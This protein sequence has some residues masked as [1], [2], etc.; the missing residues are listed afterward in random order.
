MRNRL[1]A[2]LS[3]GRGLLVPMCVTLIPVRHERIHHGSRIRVFDFEILRTQSHLVRRGKATAPDNMI[4]RLLSCIGFE[5]GIAKPE[6]VFLVHRDP[7]HSKLC[8]TFRNSDR[9]VSCSC[10]SRENRWAVALTTKDRGQA[11]RVHPHVGRKVKGQGGGSN[12]PCYELVAW[13]TW[14]AWG[15][16]EAFRPRARLA[17]CRDH[18]VLDTMVRQTCAATT[19]LHQGW[20]VTRWKL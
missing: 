10:D 14:R 11:S 7:P 5:T 13:Q 16:E 3:L 6:A 4:L 1:K 2:Y 17:T 12:V 9:I 15:H 18:V 20:L 19:N 8:S